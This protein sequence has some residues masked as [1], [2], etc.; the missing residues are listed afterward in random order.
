MN[1][2][3]NFINEGVKR[4]QDLACWNGLGVGEIVAHPSD[5]LAYELLK[6]QGET[7]VIGLSTKQSST[8]VRIEKRFPLNELFNP[9]TAEDEALSAKSELLAKQFLGMIVCWLGR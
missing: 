1:N 5:E 4:A 3:E 9:N 6:V 8:K 2:N 7:A